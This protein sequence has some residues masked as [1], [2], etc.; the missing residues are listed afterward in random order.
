M[1]KLRDHDEML[2]GLQIN[3][4]D[5]ELFQYTSLVYDDFP[6]DYWDY[7]KIHNEFIH[8]PIFTLKHSNL[9]EFVINHEVSCVRLQKSA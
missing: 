6:L 4:T 5:Y 3:L 7:K 9:G 1:N 8:N 2:Y